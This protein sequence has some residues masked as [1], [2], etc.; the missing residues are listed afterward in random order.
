MPKYFFVLCLLFMYFIFCVFAFFAFLHF[1]HICIFVLFCFIFCTFIFLYFCIYLP[2]YFCTWSFGWIVNMN[3]H[4]KYGFCSSKKVRVMS[5]FVHMYSF[6]LFGLSKWTSMKNLESVAQI[7]CEL[8][9]IY[10]SVPWRPGV[11][12]LPTYV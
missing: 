1:L 7:M 11:C 5:T 6:N 8:C 12:L 2:I 9:S 4:A 10:Y 3:F